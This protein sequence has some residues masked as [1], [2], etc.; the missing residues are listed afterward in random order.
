MGETKNL[1][2]AE[3]ISARTN[4]GVSSNVDMIIPAKYQ[5]KSGS[6]LFHD[7]P[8]Y[9]KRKNGNG[10][11]LGVYVNL[12]CEGLKSLRNK[13]VGLSNMEFQEVI[14]Q[15]KYEVEI[16]CSYYDNAGFTGISLSEAPAG[17]AETAKKG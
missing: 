16:P 2:L 14:E 6:I 3:L 1:S 10:K 13:F 8:D 17:A 15:G 9:R 4:G 5:D 12:T 11:F 7:K